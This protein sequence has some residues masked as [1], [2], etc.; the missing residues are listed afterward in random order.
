MNSVTLSK[1]AEMRIRQRGLRPADVELILQ[2]AEEIDDDVYFLRDKDAEL[3]IRR[4][5]QEIQMLERL[6]G[7][8]VVMASDTV[9]TCYRLKPSSQKRALR[10]CRKSR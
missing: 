6:R 10:R 8:K 3:E 2:C 5:K 9:V 4:R 7:Q 1:H